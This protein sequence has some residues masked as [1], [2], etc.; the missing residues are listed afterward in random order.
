MADINSI[1]SRKLW[2]FLTDKDS[3]SVMESISFKG[4][5]EQLEIE[6]A[7][8]IPH[9]P[10]YFGDDYTYFKAYKNGKVSRDEF[11]KRLQVSNME[12]RKELEKLMPVYNETL[13]HAYE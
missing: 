12:K 5:M 11:S 7:N 4:L 1:H 3:M 6:V 10:V 13:K 9:I 8:K 2:C